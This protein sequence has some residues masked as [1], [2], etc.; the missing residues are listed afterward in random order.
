M[1]G[2]LLKSL[3]DLTEEAIKFFLE[4]GLALGFLDLDVQL[5]D[6]LLDGVSLRVDLLL[7]LL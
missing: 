3:V 7:L 1:S 5:H 2:A 6:P 4:L